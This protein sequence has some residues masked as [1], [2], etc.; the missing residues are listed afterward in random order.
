[1]FHSYKGMQRDFLILCMLIAV[2]LI[3]KYVM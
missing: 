2:L 1:M 3:I